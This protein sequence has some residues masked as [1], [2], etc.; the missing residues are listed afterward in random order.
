MKTESLRALDLFAGIGGFHLAFKSV[1]P[2]GKVVMA[3]EIDE[4]C[5]ETYYENFGMSPRGDI[6]KIPSF[7]IPDFDLL[8]AGFPCQPF[9]KAGLSCLR[10]LGRKNGFEYE[11]K[12]NLFFEIVRILND[13]QP[14]AFILE[15]VP[16]LVNHNSGSTFEVI[17]RTLY[18]LGYI[19]YWEILDAYDFGLPQKR[20]RLYIVGFRERIQFEFPKKHKYYISL[21]DYYDDRGFFS[22]AVV[23]GE[24]YVISEERWERI[25]RHKAK[26]K[27]KGNN[28]GYVIVDPQIDPVPT[29]TARYWKDGQ[30]ILLKRGE[31]NRPR[32]L[33]PFECAMIMGFPHNC[34]I[35]N[36]KREA[37]KQFGNSIPIPV[38]RAII[39][40]MKTALVNPKKNPQ[41]QLLA[42]V[43]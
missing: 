26:Q 41:K 4:Y 27:R 21:Y 34:A 36:N 40:K 24:N 31:N 2:Q 14:H 13:K 33:S 9:S 16:N 6:T 1:F 11:N 30:E 43:R 38:V 25:K 12:G 15:N 32:M 7:Q 10:Y 37:Y 35:H 42:Y 20:P 8:M 5:R 29:L 3:S 28:F 17:L 23:D 19:V 39:C 22:Y 18:D